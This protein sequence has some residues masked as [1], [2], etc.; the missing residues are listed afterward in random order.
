MAAL[1]S[2]LERALDDLISNEEGMK[3][4][5]LAVVLAKKRWPDLIACERKRDL[6]ADAI[7]K[8]SFAAEGEGKVLACSITAKLAK[9]RDDAEKVREHFSG[10]HKLIFATPV[11]VS[12]ETGETWA[13]E[14]EKDFGCQLAVISR[15]DILTSLLDP[16]NISL[17]KSH[18]GIHVEIE[19]SAAEL[20]E[21]VRVAARE[22]NA[23]WLRRIADLPLIELRCLRLEADGQDSDQLLQLADICKAL[24]QS[25]RIVLEGPAGRGKTTT[26]T[27]IATSESTSGIRL[28]IDLSAWAASNTGILN[29]I[30]GM[31]QFQSRSLDAMKLARVSSLEHFSFL[32]NGWN[33]VAETDSH[34][35]ESALRGLDRNFPGAGILVATRTHH[36]LPPLRGALRVRLLTLTRAERIGYLDTRLGSRADVLR[37]RFDTDRVLNDL[38]RTPLFLSQ[39]TTLFEAGA[40]IPS[41]KTG[42]LGA[43]MD[44][45]EGSDEHRNRL[46]QPPLA[47]RARDYLG[48]LATRMTMQGRISIPEDEARS[49]VTTVGAVLRNAGQIA[50]PLDP[51][52]VLN[53]L[54]AHHILE[55]QDYPI[56]AFRFEHQQFQEFYAAL[57]ARRQ[58]SDLVRDGGNEKERRFIKTIVN[59]PAWAEPLG[60]IAEEIGSPPSGGEQADV[61]RQGKVLVSMALRIDPVFASELARFCGRAVWQEVGRDVGYRLRSLYAVPDSRYRHVAMAGM[62]AS[63]SEDFKDILV[64]ILSSNDQQKRLGLYRTWGFHLSSLGSDWLEVV[65]NWQEEARADFVFEL[66]HQ[67]YLPD[68]VLFAESD[69]SPK[70]K[71]AAIRGLMWMGAEDEATRVL[72]SVDINVSERVL[73]EFDLRL[74]P[75]AVRERALEVA[76]RAFALSD[77][78]WKRLELLLRESALGVTKIAELKEELSKVAGKTESHQAHFTIKPTLEIVQV[79]DAAWVSTWVAERVAAGALWHDTWTKFITVVPDELKEVLARR[80]ETEEVEHPAHRNIIT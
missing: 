65:R 46:Q 48:D 67:R 36:L 27:Q 5:G 21:R 24:G 4:Q 45:V 70:V 69:C 76:D 30:A 73:Q 44:L 35:A 59:E 61:L 31:P 52:D 17:V 14:I 55:R 56:V 16:S 78:P 51:A 68:V 71:E 26:L 43:V 15:E 41:T 11:A 29:F 54:C 38:T 3:F 53:G 80:L 23:G 72:Q 20:V 62:L 33:E 57:D 2:D 74:L 60:M 19:E 40:S 18:L 13:A 25:R 28:L 10:I 77:D 32:L 49:I 39:V 7:A 37:K 8:P 64:P 50:I 22:V 42:V 66:L 34:H 79:A 9:I 63:G 75:Q 1:R 6:G 47:G 12:N 58:L